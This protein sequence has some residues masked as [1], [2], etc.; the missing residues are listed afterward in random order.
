MGFAETLGSL[1][2]K[3]NATNQVKIASERVEIDRLYYNEKEL[4]F[5]KVRQFV[6]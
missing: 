4:L 1:A 6:V 5:L 3:S 2:I